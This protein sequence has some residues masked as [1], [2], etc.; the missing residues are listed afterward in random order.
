M[1]HFIPANK[2]RHVR[3]P[4]PRAAVRVR[5]ERR[6]PLVLRVDPDPEDPIGI[7]G[8]MESTAYLPDDATVLS[9]DGEVIQPTG[10]FVVSLGTLDPYHALIDL[11]C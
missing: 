3:L 11:F 4:G 9:P 8:A 2:T 6:N 10:K 1:S 5:V 7:I